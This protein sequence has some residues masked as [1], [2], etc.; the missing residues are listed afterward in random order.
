[1]PESRHLDLPARGP[2]PLGGRRA[3]RLRPAAQLPIVGGSG[4]YRGAHG[5]I[6]PPLG[7]ADAKSPAQATTPQPVCN[8]LGHTTKI[9]TEDLEIKGTEMSHTKNRMSHRPVATLAAL[10]AIVSAL[11]VAVSASAAGSAATT[12]VTTFD[13]TGAVFTCPDRS[14]TVLGGTVRFVSHDS[15]AADGSQHLRITRVPIEVTL[16]DGT[17]S[18][19]YRLVGANSAGGNISVPS[20]R[21]EFTDVTLFNIL[22]PNGGVVARVASVVH[23]SPGGRGFEFKFGECEA[24]QD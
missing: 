18:T 10:G 16:S 19:I 1:M 20:G 23:V 12:Q 3:P 9:P 14:Y 13:P 8:C 15:T 7:G 6:T 21:F 2:P 4:A 11:V 17:T 24:P 5:E 22:A